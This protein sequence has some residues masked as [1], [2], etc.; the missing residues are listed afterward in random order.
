MSPTHGIQQE[1]SVVNHNHLCTLRTFAHSTDIALAEI[2]AFAPGTL[3]AISGN[4]AANIGRELEAEGFKITVKAR[5]RDV[6]SV[7]QAHKFAV[8]HIELQ[9]CAFLLNAIETD[10]V[11]D[12]FNQC[13]VE[14]LDMFLDKG[15]VFVEELFLKC[16]IGCADNG[17]LTGAYN[18]HEVGKAFSSTSSRFNDRW[19]MLRN[20]L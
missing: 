19:D 20:S 5:R 2:I 15:D 10:I 3:I 13:G 16:F 17:D 4:L 9:T 1:E 14:G 8:F 12:T 18:W 7:E 11:V 6:E